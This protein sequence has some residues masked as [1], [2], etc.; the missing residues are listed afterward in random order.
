MKI[1]WLHM[2]FARWDRAIEAL[3]RP[4]DA[5]PPLGWMAVAASLVDLV[6]NRFVLR[7]WKGPHQVLIELQWWG[8]AMRNLAAVTGLIALFVA[9]FTFLINNTAFRLWRRVGVASVSGIFTTVMALACVIPAAGRFVNIGPMTAASGAALGTQ[10]A[11]TGARRSTHRPTALACLL[12]TLTGLFMFLTLAIE[13]TELIHGSGTL[14]QA[15]EF[16][17][18]AGEAC[19]LLCLLAVVAF[20]PESPDLRSSRLL[21]LF[22]LVITAFSA[23]S[24]ADSRQALGTTFNTILEGALDLNLFVDSRPEVYALWFSV[25]AGASA[26]GLFHPNPAYRQG[27][28]AVLLLLCAGFFPRTPSRALMFVLGAACLGRTSVAL[29]DPNKTKPALLLFRR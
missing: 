17:R 10:L 15:T 14:L 23:I 6:L 19:Y 25:V 29:H 5:L 16:F 13:S 28:A 18:L 22:A 12:L 24:L 21:G 26:I 20:L 1:S 9:L 7:G 2:Q 27:T 4:L 3:R 11:L 8:D